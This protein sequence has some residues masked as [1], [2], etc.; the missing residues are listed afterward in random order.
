MKVHETFGRTI[1]LLNYNHKYDGD[2]EFNRLLNLC[3]S[4]RND[5]LY[6]NECK[7]NAALKQYA[8]S[9]IMVNKDYKELLRSIPYID[10]ENCFKT[11]LNTFRK[12]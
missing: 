7:N 8:I 11:H 4:L 2:K 12:L 5:I 1:E 3:L 6:Y 9:E 10:I